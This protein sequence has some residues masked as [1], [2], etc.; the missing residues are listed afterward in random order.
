MS[1]AA[2]NGRPGE[3][4][5]YLPGL[6][7]TGRL[8]HRQPALHE[9][10]SVHCIRYSQE[11]LTTYRELAVLVIG[12]LQEKGPAIVLAESFSGPVALIV[13]RER[14][15]LVRRM[16]LVNTFA[17]FPRRLVI[18]LA[19]RVGPHLPPR[20]SH[21]WSRGLRGLLFFASQIPA[22]ERAEWWERTADVPMR[23]CGHRFAMIAGVDLRPL[24]PSIRV[25]A[26]VLA[27][28]N[29]R[30]VPASA[31]RQLAG[32]LSRAHLLQPRVSHAALIHP[33]VDVAALLANSAYWLPA[34]SS[35]IPLG[36]SGSLR[37]Q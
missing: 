13:A 12:H 8:L 20:P 11:V 34:G 28:P 9:R 1:P 26:L 35:A 2:D 14:P 17:Y 32:L 10:Y 16:V 19:A 4:L 5:L 18:S 31:G 6:D 36:A 7:G 24:L 27:A 3:L 37:E 33:R 15:D 23:A 21:P 25:P 30:L 29:D 22:A